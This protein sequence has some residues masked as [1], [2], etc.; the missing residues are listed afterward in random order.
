MGSGNIAD[1]GVVMWPG[2]TLRGV[3]EQEC[4][5]NHCAYDDTSRWLTGMTWCFVPGS[6]LTRQVTRVVG[7]THQSDCV[8]GLYFSEKNICYFKHMYTEIM[9]AA[10]QSDC[11]G[12]IFTGC[13][14]GKCLKP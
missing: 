1:D 10:N 2:D 8:G 5:R 4:K 9:R 12:G 7:C 6:T 11:L 13:G 3:S 14:G